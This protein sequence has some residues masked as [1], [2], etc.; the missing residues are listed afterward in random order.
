MRLRRQRWLALAVTMAIFLIALGLRFAAASILPTPFPFLVFFPAIGVATYFGGIRMGLLVALL[1]VALGAYFIAQPSAPVNFLGLAYFGL[2]A[3]SICYVIG[4][5]NQTLEQNLLLVQQLRA[6]IA[7]AEAAAAAK[8]RIMARIGHDLKLPLQTIVGTLDLLGKSRQ[9][10]SDRTH[11]ERAHRAVALQLRALDNLLEA[12]RLELG[13]RAPAPRCFALADA[14]TA[15]AEDCVPLAERKGLRFRT[16]ASSAIVVTD[17]EMLMTMLRNLAGNAIKYTP[18]GGGV[19]VG[20]RRRGEAQRIDIV[21]NGIGIE[22][23]KLSHIFDEF[24]QTEEESDGVGLGLAIV[25]ET[26]N[27]LKCR[28]EA[29]SQPGRG[30]RFSIFLP[31]AVAAGSAAADR[32]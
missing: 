10:E 25:K 17:Y 4:M 5:F 29:A 20:V 15:L 24:F 19:V 30:T 26:G 31:R 28:I 14:L 12:A 2:I 1:A 6:A 13:Q 3:V 9:N 8:T 32:V 11:I 21:D 16:V 22:S 7:R 23:D 27:L 18:R